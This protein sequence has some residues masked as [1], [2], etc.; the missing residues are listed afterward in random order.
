VSAP[1]NAENIPRNETRV[2]VPTDIAS[3]DNDNVHPGS[4]GMSVASSLKVLPIHRIPSRLRNLAPGACGR[5]DLFV[6]SIGSEA[7]ASG[8]ASTGLW[9]HV[10]TPNHGL[11]GPDAVVPLTA[12]RDSLASTQNGWSIDEGV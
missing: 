1:I 8:P 3:D 6:W 7:F 4:H 9:L 12:F 11:L 5:S 10:D 2:R